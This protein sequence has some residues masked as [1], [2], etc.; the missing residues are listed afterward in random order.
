MRYDFGSVAGTISKMQESIVRPDWYYAPV[1]S[2]IICVSYAQR[3]PQTDPD[4]IVVQTSAGARLEWDGVLI[5]SAGR[6][7]RF[8]I[9]R[10]KPGLHTLRVS[11]AGKIPV[12]REITVAAGRSTDIILELR[13][14]TG[15]V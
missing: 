10:P 9:S 7:G 1:L 11:M 6:D 5:G 13:D 15:K 2:L 14:T 3:L 12:S 8:V 4:Q